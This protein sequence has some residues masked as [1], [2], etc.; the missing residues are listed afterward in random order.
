[1]YFFLLTDNHV[2]CH[3][4]KACVCY[5]G[6]IFTDPYLFLGGDEVGPS[7]FAQHPA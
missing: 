4:T 1:M 7:C 6:V 3:V 5:T 2:Q